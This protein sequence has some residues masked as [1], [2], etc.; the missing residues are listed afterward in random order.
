MAD[1]KALEKVAVRADED[2]A[3]ARAYY[4]IANIPVDDKKIGELAAAAEEAHKSLAAAVAATKPAAPAK[5]APG[6]A[7]GGTLMGAETT[8]LIATV[9][10]RMD[11][12]ATSMAHLYALRGT[13]L[14]S[15]RVDNKSVNRKRRVCVRCHIEGYSAEAI[16]SAELAPN[17]GETFDLFPP[18]F[19]E[20]TRQLMELTAGALHVRVDDLDSEKVELVMAKPIPMLPPTTAVLGYRDPQTGATVDQREELAAYV[21]PNSPEI[22][23]L[24]RTAVDGSKMKAMIGYQSMSVDDVREQVRAIYSALA[25]AKITY[26]DTRIA[27]GA[28]AGQILQRIRLPRE[29][30]ESQSANCIDG[31]VLMASL[32]EATGLDPFLVIVPG[33]AYLAYRL[34]PKGGDLEYVETT[35][36]SSKPFDEAV[37][38][39]TERSST[40]SSILR[41]DVR[42]LR[43]KGITPME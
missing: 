32:L 15:V 41:L 35:V 4:A 42:E 14:V 9:T 2:L 30:I 38:I 24:L 40:T 37:K 29:S 6:P 3:R 20:K 31:T 18:V 36:V 43:A 7:A 23:E 10:M 28:G 19:P 5:A 8:E 21:T 34:Q 12:L 33:H 39:A 17:G 1:V 25:A 27:F 11:R 26:V 13:P 22:L 16:A